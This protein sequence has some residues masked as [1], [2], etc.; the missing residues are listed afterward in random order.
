MRNGTVNTVT[1][2]LLYTVSIYQVG[3]TR[4]CLISDVKSN[5]S[6]LM[7]VRDRLYT[8][9]FVSWCLTCTEIVRFMMTPNKAKMV[10]R[11]IT[12]CEFVKIEK[13]CIGEIANICDAKRYS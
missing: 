1:I 11:S 2:H 4:T 8:F 6:T 5:N 12:H 9:G 10:D 13:L 3:H 7:S